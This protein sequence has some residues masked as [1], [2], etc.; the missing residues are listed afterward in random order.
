MQITQV[1]CGDDNNADDNGYCRNKAAVPLF[2]C[3]V[4]G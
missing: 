3:E 4:Q 2:F 1:S